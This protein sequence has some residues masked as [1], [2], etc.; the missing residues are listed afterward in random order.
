VPDV[1]H[2]PTSQ[3]PALI[4][5]EIGICRFADDPT[6]CNASTGTNVPRYL[7]VNVVATTTTPINPTT[8]DPAKFVDAFGEQRLGSGTFNNYITLDTSTAT[9]IQSSPNPGAPGYEPDNDTYPQTSD[10]GI[11]MVAWSIQVIPR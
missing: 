11:E 3:N 7:Q 9:T 1:I 2:A 10:P 5:F 8:V 6:A 4:R